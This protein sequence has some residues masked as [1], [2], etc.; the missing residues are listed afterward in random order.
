MVAPFRSLVSVRTLSET[1]SSLALKID[2]IEVGPLELSLLDP[3]FPVLIPKN[4]STALT[5]LEER[6]VKTFCSFSQPIEPEDLARRE[7]LTA[8]Q[9]AL[10]KKWGYPYVL[11]QFRYHLT[12][13]DPITEGQEDLNRDKLNYLDLL[14]SLLNDDVTSELKIDS[15]C[16]CRQATK[17]SPFKVISIANFRANPDHLTLSGDESVKAHLDKKLAHER[18]DNPLRGGLS[19]HD[20]PELK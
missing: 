12:L 9:R 19:G 1:L 4:T 6:L 10:A 2:P 7:P 17:D 13:G 20:S 14:R 15:L 16:L 11:D 3:G 5:E 8:R 18:H